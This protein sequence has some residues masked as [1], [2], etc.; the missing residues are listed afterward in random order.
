MKWFKPRR[1]SARSASRPTRSK[2][3]VFQFSREAREFGIPAVAIRS[4]SDNVDED[5]PLNFAG[6]ADE[7]GHIRIGMVIGRLARAPHRLPGVLRLGRQ[8]RH[9]AENLAK[10]LDAFV[11][12]LASNEKSVGN[13]ARGCDGMNPVS[14][15]FE[16]LKQAAAANGTMRA[17]VY[18]G[19]R[20]VVVEDVPVP[21]ICDGEILFRVAACGICGTD[22]K[23]IHHGFV[24][25]PVILGHELSG[26]VVKVGRGVTAFREGDRVVSFHHIPCGAC[27][28]C[29]RKLVFAVP[30]I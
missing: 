20:K 25:P 11:G 27:F 28:Y 3:K 14:A 18:R 23:K 13:P 5:L 17:G 22:L 12:S 4:I 29:E 9:G 16:D 24:D 1:K 15:Q 6:V 2:W 10:F 26:T 7:H 30:G 21:E 8:S 19:N